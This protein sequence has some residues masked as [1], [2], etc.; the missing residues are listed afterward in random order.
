MNYQQ[1]LKR[2]TLKTELFDLT[3]YT[4]LDGIIDVQNNH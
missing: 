2:K 3:I 4:T 1:H